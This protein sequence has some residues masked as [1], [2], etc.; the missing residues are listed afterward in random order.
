MGYQESVIK[1][2]KTYQNELIE[3]IINSDREQYFL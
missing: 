2:K 3:Q 1:V